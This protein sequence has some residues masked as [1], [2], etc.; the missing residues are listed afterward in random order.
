MLGASHDRAYQ[1]FLTLLTKFMEVTVQTQPGE[2]TALVRQKFQGL[3]RYFQ[4]EIAQLNDLNLPPEIAARWQSVQTEILREFKLLSTDILF[5]A[6]AKTNSTQQK[7]LKSIES[8]L[9]KLLGYCQIMLNK[10][11]N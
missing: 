10:D 5:L 11:S 9:T 8:R 7:R 2:E 6:S 1:D 3:S 4:A